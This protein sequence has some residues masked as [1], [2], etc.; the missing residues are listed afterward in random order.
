MNVRG[1]SVTVV[2]LAKSGVS[3]ALLLKERGADVR[4]TDAKKADDLGGAAATLEQAGVRLF[5]GGHPDEALAGSSLVVT[6]PGVPESAKPLADARAKGIETIGELEL[7]WR[8]LPK[9]T[10]VVAI[11][12]SN[13]K[14]TT[15]TLVAHLL[16]ASGI[17]TWVGGNLGTPLAEL[18]RSG[19][20]PK[21][22]VVE[23][24][25]FML[26][27][28]PTFAPSAAAILNVSANHLDRH[29]T[30][31]EYAAIK[32]R[33]WKNAGADA[34]TVFNRD[35][36]AVAALAARAPGRHLSFGRGALPD[37]GGSRFGWTS[38]EAHVEVRLPGTSSTSYPGGGNPPS[39][40]ERY[41]L[42]AFPAPGAHNAA[43]AAAAILL[44]RLSG[45]T[46]EAIGPALATFVPLEHRLERCGEKAG[47][48]F[49]N[50]SKATTST[51]LAKSV[52]VFEKNLV[53]IAGGK[54]KGGDFLALR[55]LFRARVRKLVTFGTHKDLI[56]DALEGATDVHRE[57][58][59]AKAFATAT[60]RL[61]TGDVVLFASYDQFA[62]LEERGRAFKALVAA[63]VAVNAGGTPA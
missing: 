61:R 54:D 57:P 63:H 1:T 6:S 18:V 30:L 26:E 3:A 16:A 51:A 36:S 42:A 10:A 2:G 48:V 13:G 60:K 41:D 27:T 47:V 28:A 33:I 4:A 35:D 55:E 21:V 14:S 9:G 12:G 56:A 5:L 38:R 34:W 44:A 8:L 40:P 20:T 25:S 45:A 62:N 23:V 39:P 52:E 31:A 49:Y 7:A 29:P 50:D 11:T 22:A 15:T 59:L 53:V 46:P 19:K 43:N 17:D 32:A 58:D 24:S 37:A